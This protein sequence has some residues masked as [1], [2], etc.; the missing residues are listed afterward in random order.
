M[1]PDERDSAYLWDIADAAKDVQ[2]FLSGVS[3][4]EY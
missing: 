1:R 3:W 2:N 4:L